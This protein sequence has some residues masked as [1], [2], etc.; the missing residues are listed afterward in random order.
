MSG[1][2]GFT[3]LQGSLSDVIATAGSSAG[4]AY[5]SPPQAD[6]SEWQRRSSKH[7]EAL[8]HIVF[9]SDP[10]PGGCASPLRQRPSVPWPWPL[11]PYPHRTTPP[12]P[13]KGPFIHCTWWACCWSSDTDFPPGKG[14]PPQDAWI[15]DLLKTLLCV[16]SKREEICFCCS[17]IL[18]RGKAEVCYFLEYEVWYWE[19]KP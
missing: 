10:T 11:T 3:L 15:S 14:M 1:W 16:W 19:T 13:T 18:T 17:L 7:G 9:L 12:A 4:S 2:W 6:S 5:G 8:P